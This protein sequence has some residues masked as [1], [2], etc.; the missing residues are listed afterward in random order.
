MKRKILLR[1]LARGQ[2]HSF[3]GKGPAT[4]TQNESVQA[5]LPSEGRISAFVWWFWGNR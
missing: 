2:P 4:E 3:M 1:K 5:Q